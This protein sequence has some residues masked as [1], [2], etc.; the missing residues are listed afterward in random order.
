M[1]QD[2]DPLAQSFDAVVVGTDVTQAVVAAALARIGRKV[3]HVDPEQVYG[4]SYATREASD[5]ISA[6]SGDD[7]AG[8]ERRAAMR[9]AVVDSFL[10]VVFARGAAVNTLVSAGIAS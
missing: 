2:F 6:A 1:A 5:L 8:Q 9:G 7:E 4:G 3:L 10:P